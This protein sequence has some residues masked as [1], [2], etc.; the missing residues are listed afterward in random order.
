MK[1]DSINIKATNGGRVCSLRAG[2]RDFSF[3]FTD[4]VEFDR[5][6]AEVLL[7]TE[8][9]V[10]ANAI[11]ADQRDVLQIDSFYVQDADE[12]NKRCIAPYEINGRREIGQHV[13]GGKWYAEI[14]VNGIPT[15]CGFNT[16]EELFQITQQIIG[17][18]IA[19]MGSLLQP[20]IAVAHG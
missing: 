16:V 5:Y 20:A 6:V 3:P 14:T 2:G 15:D 18:E 4:L 8:G 12:Y 9:L 7:V 19:R 10:A 13:C 17:R 11:T 1:I